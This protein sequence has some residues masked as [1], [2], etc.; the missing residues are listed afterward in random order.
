MV[1]KIA[2]LFLTVGNIFN[3]KTWVNFF[4]DAQ[5]RAT[6]YVHSKHHLKKTSFFREFE[7]QKK[8]PTQ[9]DKT[10][11]AQVALLKEALKDPDNQKFVFLSETTIP[12]QNFDDMYNRLMKH[13]RSNFHYQKN[14]HASRTFGSIPSDHIHFNSQWVILN[15]KHAELMA[16][17][18]F[19]INEMT[20]DRFDNEHYPSTFLASKKMLKEVEKKDL[21]MVVWTGD[22]HPHEF[23]NLSKDPYKDDLLKVIN[24]KR[25][26]FARKF[27][28]C[29]LSLL[30]ELLPWVE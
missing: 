11:K 5:D 15:R 21:T 4:A 20:R 26:L 2:F 3:E 22:K 16:E 7:M 27:K 19:F 10:M 17:D 28:R 25:F 30:K 18:S 14:P 13:D 6:I 12:L 1:P 29:D 23:S 8:V 24:K 9:W